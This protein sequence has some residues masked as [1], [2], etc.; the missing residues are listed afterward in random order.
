MTGRTVVIRAAADTPRQLDGDS[1]GP[2][3]ELRM[4]VHP[5]P[6][7]G[8][9]PALTFPAQLR[10]RHRRTP[11]EPVTA[12]EDSVV[13]AVVGHAGPT[14]DPTPSVGWPASASPRRPCR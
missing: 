11:R 4:D 9:R 1:I 5:R 6:A 10:G 2:G 7:A 14:S 12:A 8:A 3:R 13:A